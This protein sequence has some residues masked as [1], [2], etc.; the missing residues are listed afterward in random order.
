MR[1]DLQIA[2][3]L[4][5][6]VAA[7]FFLSILECGEFFTEVQAPMASLTF[8]RHKLAGDLL[9]VAPI[10]ASAAE[11]AVLIS[12]SLGALGMY[13]SISL[14]SAS[15]LSASSGR[16]PLRNMSA[17]SRRCFTSVLSNCSSVA[18]SSGF[19]ESTSYF[20]KAVL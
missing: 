11:I 19:I 1:I 14:S 16:P 8:I 2:A 4:R 10:S 6:Q 18:S 12:S 5:Q 13:D 9:T 3:H 17:A 15:S 20:F 7:D